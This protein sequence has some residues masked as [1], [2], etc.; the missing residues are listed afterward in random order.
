MDEGHNLINMYTHFVL[1]WVKQ[2]SW[3]SIISSMEIVSTLYI[4]MKADAWLLPMC[5]SNAQYKQHIKPF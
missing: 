5:T 1:M 4:P 3:K 2:K